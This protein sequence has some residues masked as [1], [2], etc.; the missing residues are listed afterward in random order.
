MS[1]WRNDTPPEDG[2]TILMRTVQF[3]RFKP[4][5]LTSQQA[6]AGIK[7]RWQQMNEFGGWENRPRPL[8]C[9]WSPATEEPTP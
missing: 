5:K 2:T 4:Y 9:E 1:D 6:R 3:L 7:G 8:G